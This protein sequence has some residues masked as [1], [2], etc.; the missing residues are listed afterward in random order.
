[1]QFINDD[2]LLALFPNRPVALIGEPGKQRLVFLDRQNAPELEEQ[3]LG[4]Q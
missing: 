1:M 4:V 3:E 2:E